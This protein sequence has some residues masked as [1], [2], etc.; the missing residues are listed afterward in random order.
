MTVIT[1]SRQLGSGGDEIAVAVAERLGLRLV[2]QELINRAAREA[3]APEV[4]LAA[5]DELGLLGVRPGRAAVRAY[6]EK[7]YAVVGELTAEGRLLLVGRGGQVILA[8]QPGVLHV[9]VIA[10]GELRVTR[11]AETRG[12]SHEAAAARIE[13][14]DR[15]RVDFV[16]RYY[17]ANSTDPT[18]YDLL[19]NMVK[20]D[21]MT[22]VELMCGA[23]QGISRMQVEGR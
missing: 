12:I 3:G 23:A 18:L 19:L 5:I 17:G 9:R 2:G 15:A 21:I 20:I 14:S 13:A 4:A 1:L 22:A 16:R 10:P 11:L 6:R 7:I 8:G